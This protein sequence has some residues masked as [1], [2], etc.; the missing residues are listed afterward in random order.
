[1]VIVLQD[2]E[3]SS[4]VGVGEYGDELEELGPA[5]QE[6]G[7]GVGLMSRVKPGRRYR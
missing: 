1:L 2:N 4:H 3:V 7:V 5:G 6:W